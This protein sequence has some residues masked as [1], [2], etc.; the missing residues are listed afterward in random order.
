MT[1][2]IGIAIGI[3]I[4]AVGMF[5]KISEDI[6]RVILDHRARKQRELG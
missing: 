1:L 6:A 5:L 4:G 2:F 3:V